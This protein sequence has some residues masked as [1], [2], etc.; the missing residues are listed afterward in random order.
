M[1]AATPYVLD[2][3]QQEAV[4][5]Y[6]RACKQ[7]LDR[8]PFREHFEYIDREYARENITDE[9]YIKMI[10]ELKQGRKKFIPDQIIP[11]VMPHVEAVVTHLTSVFLTGYPIFGVTS[12]PTIINEAQQME[13]IIKENSTRGAWIRHLNMFF[14]DGVKYNRGAIECDWSQEY[15]YSAAEGTPNPATRTVEPKKLLWEG[16]HLQR[17]DPY[18]TFADLS[19]CP[20]EVH[21][22][23][24][25]AG[26]T[27]LVSRVRL[28]EM[29]RDLPAEFTTN[30][31]EAFESAQGDNRTYYVPKVNVSSLLAAS[32]FLTM[33]PNDGMN[34]DAWVGL[35]GAKKE[36]NYKD[37]YEVSTLYA[38]IIPSD[39]NINGPAKNTPQIWKFKIIN[40]QVI[41]YAERKTNAHSKLPILFSQ[42]VEDGLIF[43]TKGIAENV[44]NAQD[45]ASAMWNLNLAAKRRAI[46]DRLFYDPARI[47]K[48]DI[49]SVNPIG[50]IPV[51]SAAYGKA[52]EEAV[53]TLPFRDE[54]SGSLIQE[55]REISQHA[56]RIN[57]INA[58]QQG[59]FQKG[60]KTRQEWQD[61]MG[62]SNDR[63]QT[64]ALFIESQTFVPLK[65]IIKTNILQY[66]PPG[67]ITPPG[68]AEP[69]KISPEEIR[70]A[71]IG[72]QLSDGMLP[73]D[74]LIAGDMLQ[75]FLQFM[76]SSPQAQMEFDIIGAFAYYCKIGG[77]DWVEQFRKTPQQQQ[78]ALANMQATTAANTSTPPQPPGVPA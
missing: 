74:K 34:W 29:L 26:Y 46:Y 28:K 67:T 25:F 10:W 55:A 27:E 21:S 51:K 8:L 5:H 44:I 63:L 4:I 12:S 30:A 35:S 48:E 38:R 72:F 75:A 47:R 50:R 78:Q 57:G 45:T 36:I 70:K 20:A 73:S 42:P 23:G 17:L 15:Y 19:V 56:D 68:S 59:Q 49:N 77:A 39:F 65:E 31:K 32:E 71:N 18:N 16:N 54:V 62:R 43:Q 14:R 64:H 9:T 33:H 58:V 22:K 7:N 52:V 6:F 40:G 69:V 41:I 3:K 2:K 37:F 60:N 24:E 1:A 76:A 13:A 53:Y 66:Q 61:T 11:I